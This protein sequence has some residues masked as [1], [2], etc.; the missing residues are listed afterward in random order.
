MTE[1]IRYD[2]VGPQLWEWYHYPLLIVVI[3]FVVA[4]IA[5]LRPVDPDGRIDWQILVLGL[6]GWT[7]WAALLWS[8]WTVIL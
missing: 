3:L 2:P 7:C 4:P 6:V 5:G 1:E 8:L